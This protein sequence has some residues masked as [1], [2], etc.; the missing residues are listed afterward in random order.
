MEQLRELANS[1]LTIIVSLHDL[2][3]IARY[4][5]HVVLLDQGELIV[6]GTP[7]DTLTH[8][9]IV[10]IYGVTIDVSK[11][12]GVPVYTPLSAIK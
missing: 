12:N 8:Q 4:C 5:N 11:V 2:S 7:Q 3:Q 1:G 9:N 10:D 6:Q